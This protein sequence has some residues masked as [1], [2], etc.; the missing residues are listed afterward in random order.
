MLI[1]RRDLG[2]LGGEAVLVG[3]H[4]DLGRL[5]G[6]RERRVGPVAVNSGG[7]PITPAHSTVP[8]CMPWP[9]SA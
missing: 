7:E 4:V 1:G 6:A 5:A 3:N 9:V 2:A 8:P